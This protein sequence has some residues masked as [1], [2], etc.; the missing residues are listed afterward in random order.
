MLSI[1]TAVHNQLPVNRL[2]WEHLKRYTR[3]PFELIVIDN[4]STDGSAAFFESV[5]A[6]V[7]R[8]PANYSYPH[9]Q[10]QGIAA[11]RYDWLAFLNND[12]IVSPD[13]DDGLM[14]TMEA[15][16]L[17]ACTVCGVEQVENAAATR[18]LKRRW[19]RIK[20]LVGL[21]GFGEWQL[22]LM[23][24]WMYGDWEAF[25]RSRRERFALQVK[26]GF[27]GNTVMLRRRALEKI[28][29]WD[30]RVQAGD[31][32]LYLRTVD[33]AQSVGDIR[34]LHLALD[35][36]VHHYIRLTLRTPYPPFADRDRLIELGDKW[37]A[38]A[39]RA[40]DRLNK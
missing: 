13:W 8:N 10:N 3:H 38:E 11:A 15:N 34:P 36:F 12:I 17:D 29:L 35:V 37:P 4:A 39:R 27:V 24:K 16:G 5:G 23:H 22:R 26:E 1:I 25:C 32:D 6:T 14:K 9:A 7:I 21:F 33:R 31:F 19:K 18:K 20:N 2:Y 40:L 28:G 30:E